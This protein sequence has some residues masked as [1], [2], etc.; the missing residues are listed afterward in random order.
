[1]V[2]IAGSGQPLAI[3]LVTGLGVPI[4][5]NA[6]TFF[7]T[8]AALLEKG[9]GTGSMMAPIVASMEVRIPEFVLLASLFRWRLMAA[10]VASVFAVAVGG[11]V[12]FALA[13]G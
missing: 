5:V 6:E 11:G 1:M 4:N 7:P 2:A 9:V 10:L 13:L 3:P 12:L 8:S